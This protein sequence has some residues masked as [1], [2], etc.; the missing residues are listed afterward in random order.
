MKKFKLWTAI[1][2]L[3]IPVLAWAVAYKGS[4]LE[5]TGNT[6][7]GGNLA[8]TGQSDF[9]GALHS[10]NTATFQTTTHLSTATFVGGIHG[11]GQTY[12]DDLY[13]GGTHR[14]AWP[15][16]LDFTAPGPIGGGTPDTGNFT[17]ITAVDI[18][19]TNQ[20]TLGGT[21]R[22]SWP[23]A[24]TAGI[25][26]NASDI[27]A[28]AMALQESHGIEQLLMEEGFK[29]SFNASTTRID[30]ANS[31]GYTFVS[32]GASTTATPG[33]IRNAAGGAGLTSNVPF[34][35]ESDYLQQEW[36]KANQATSF[37]SSTNGSTNLTI[38]SGTFPAN[39]TNGR[40]SLDGGTTWYDIESI[41]GTGAALTASY[42]GA[43]GN[44]NDWTGRM[45]EFSSGVVQLNYGASVVTSFYEQATLTGDDEVIKGSGGT[46]EEVGQEFKATQTANIVSAVLRL[47]KTGSP[48]D[49]YVYEL[50]ASTTPSAAG[51]LP[52]GSSLATT[53][54]QAASG[55]TTS[56]ADTEVFFP[57]PYAPTLN[58][59]YFLV[60]RRTGAR[61]VSN[62]LSAEDSAADGYANGRRVRKENGAWAT[63]NANDAYFR[64]G[65]GPSSN[66]ANEYVSISSTYANRADTAAWSDINSLTRTETLNS[67]NAWYWLI[68]NPAPSYGNGTTAKI[69]NAA[70][71]VWRNIARNNGGT[72]EYNNDATATASETWVGAT[73]NDMLHAVSKAVFAQA[74]NRMTGAQMAAVTD[75]NLTAPSTS[76]V[77]GVTLQSSST[78]QN[79]SVDNIAVNYDSNSSALDL[80]TSAFAVSSA[81]GQLYGFVADKQTTGTSAY[82]VSRDG[83]ANWYSMTMSGVI[84]LADGR[85]IRRGT[86]D[87]TGTASGIDIR[88]KVTVPSGSTYEISGIGLQSRQ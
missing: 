10:S 43:T 14:T 40:I 57:V 75:G 38:S 45:T 18:M 88:M 79:P 74:N 52:T 22:S 9:T 71:G 78:S 13:L 50:H 69:W 87:M 27:Q 39:F 2:F 16:G 1:I 86:K 59:Y 53:A 35:T 51:G 25:L 15:A 8:V 62:Y 55:L 46:D 31:T 82:Y 33:Y 48:T 17:T 30:T 12:L 72:W 11:S 21:A 6:T 26:V 61:D 23:S 3:S 29:A 42:A 5:S 77:V 67:Q 7:V 85:T 84:N 4:T 56:Y 37:V 54:N 65:Q 81:P 76:Q 83:G 20:I 36:T 41:W 58:N 34:T 66:V 49:S 28:L 32:G 24:D 19:S 47:K 70:G 63:V 73:V 44:T 64:I 68:D 60:V 80:R